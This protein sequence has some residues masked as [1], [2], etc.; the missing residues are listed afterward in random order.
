ML[1]THPY[2][3]FPYHQAITPM[4]TPVTSDPRFNDGYYFAFYRE[5]RHVFC[6]LRFHPNTN[7]VDG[8]AGA[9]A[10]GVQRGFRATRAM[11]IDRSSMAVGPLRVE[12]IE[13]MITQRIICAENDFGIE[14]DV[15]LTASCP[16]FS[17]AP[18]IQYRHG[19]LLNHVLRYTQPVRAI[20]VVSIDGGEE[21][22]DDWFGARDHSWGI[23]QTM[24]P[25][26]PVHGSVP[27][28]PDPR[29]LRLWVPFEVGDHAGFFHLH[30]DAN[31]TVL[32]CEGRLE[33]ANGP[34]GP[35]AD[36]VAVEHHLRYVNDTKRL[37]AGTFELVLDSGDRVPLEFGVVCAPAHPQG[38]GYT[39]GWSDG[40]NPGVW[41]G[42]YLIEGERFD[43]SDP[44][45]LAGPEHTDPTR[46]LGGT[47]FVSTMVG[48]HGAVGMAHVEHMLYA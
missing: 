38:F 19:R 33:P 12:I 34:G 37:S 22:V 44:G 28:P 2:D 15:T 26:L 3:D 48:P 17:E 16:A 41:R 20:G 46:R 42:V 35:G 39:R 14:F 9:V 1:P 11:D 47:E 4:G 13:P 43:V 31:G 45:A 7:V 40:G 24:G 27:P 18:H 6:G 23:R 30:E 32:D 21:P 8:Y 5:E 29:A 36:I 25:A 10:Q